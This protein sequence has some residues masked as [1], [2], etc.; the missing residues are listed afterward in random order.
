MQKRKP[1]DLIYKLEHQFTL[2]LQRAQVTRAML[3]PD[4]LIEMRKAFYGGLGQMFFLITQDVPAMGGERNQVIVLELFQRQL[5]EFWEEMVKEFEKSHLG[6][7]HS[8]R[9]QKCPWEGKTS[10]LVKPESKKSGLCKCPQCGSEE[11]LYK[12]PDA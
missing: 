9:C 3:P 5:G 8:I 10:E 12:N 1:T 4:Q 2:Y 6:P 11:L 7:D